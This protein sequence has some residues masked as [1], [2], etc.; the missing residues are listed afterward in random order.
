MT[1]ITIDHSVSPPRFQGEPLIL[2]LVRVFSY[3]P[4]S[5]AEPD[6]VVSEQKLVE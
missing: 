1:D 3:S 2:E 5:A 6:I 4:T